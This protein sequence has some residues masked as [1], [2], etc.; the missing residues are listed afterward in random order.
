MD[1]GF[2]F[3][4]TRKLFSIGYRVADGALDRQ[5]LRPARL[6]GA[7]G[8]LRRHRQGRRAR[9]ALVPP[10]PPADAGRA[11]LGARL[12]VGLDVRVPDARARDGCARR[13]ACS[14][15]RAG[16]WSG[17]RSSYGAERGVPWGIS[18]SA[19]NVRDLELTYQYSNFGVPR[20]RPQARPRRG[21]RRRA[22]RDRAG[23]DGRSRGGG[24]RTSRALAA[25]GARGPLRLLR[26][27][28]LHAVAPAGGRDG[29]DR[30]RVHGPPPGHD[31]RRA[32]ERAARR[33][34]CGAR[35]H[36]E[37]DRPGD[38]AA[39]AGAHAARRRGRAPAGRGGATCR[40]T[41]ASSWRRSCGASPSPHD[42]APRTHLLS[43]GRYAV[44]VTAA[45]SGYSRWPASPSRAG[46]RT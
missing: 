2:L 30:A 31:A 4:P 16:S 5:L 9:R 44:M 17:A 33:A 20:P 26:G 25:A 27:D 37:P 22:L 10:R 35:F 15:R 23:R 46:A 39:A 12:L 40:R 41:C 36:A 43:N 24:A 1:F 8:E 45:G 18:E 11:R 13:A 19:Y 29:R 34:R 21:P 42:A 32:R 6:R 38:R 28:R 14:S 3:D 7:A